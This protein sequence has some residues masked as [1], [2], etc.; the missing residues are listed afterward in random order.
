M[1]MLKSVLGKR[2]SSQIF[3]T[4]KI[5][6]KVVAKFKK[7]GKLIIDRIYEGKCSVA[8]SRNKRISRLLTRVLR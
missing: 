7:Y 5:F 3:K 2:L 8:L 4:T 6:K 1:P